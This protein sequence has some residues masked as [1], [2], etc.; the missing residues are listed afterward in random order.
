VAQIFSFHFLLV[1]KN[2]NINAQNKFSPQR[3]PDIKL[4]FAEGQIFFPILIVSAPGG[5]AADAARGT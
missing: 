1:P 4:L 3:P 2:F 5:P